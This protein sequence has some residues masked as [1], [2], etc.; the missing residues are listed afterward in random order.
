MTKEEAIDII[1]CLAWHTRPDEEDVEQAIKALE[2]QPCDLGDARED[3]MHDVYNTLDFLPTNNEANRIIDS[4]DRVTR[5]LEQQPCDDCI[6]RQAVEK[7]IK[8]E[9]PER[10][11]WEIEGD[12][13]K[14][15]VCEVC[16]DLIQE[17]YKLPPAIP[18]EKTGRWISFG[19]QGEIDGQIVKVFVCSECGAISVFRMVDGEIVNGDLCPNCGCQMV[20][21]QESEDK[22]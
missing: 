12:T 20:K 22:K 7:M 5:G 14:E 10:G 6:S 18:Q 8:A 1:K 4:F 9:M 16:V 21:P 13:A 2:Q 17:L 19:I 11:M 15:T 3:F